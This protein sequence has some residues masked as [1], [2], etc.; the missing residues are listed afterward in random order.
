MNRLGARLQSLLDQHLIVI[1]LALGFGAY[2][3]PS[4]P[5]L[6]FVLDSK[7]NLPWVFVLA[8][9][10]IGSVL[11]ADEVRRTISSWRGV[12]FGTLAQY[13]IMPL[14]AFSLAWFI[15]MSED[16]RLGLIIC[17][18]VPG[19]MASNV[20]TLMARGNVSYSVGVTTC[21]TFLSPVVVPIMFFLFL[22]ASAQ[23]NLV[24]TGVKL[25]WQV[26]LPVMIGFGL[27]RLSRTYAEFMAGWGPVLANLAV[28]WIVTFVVAENRMYLIDA[29]PQLFLALL[30]LNLLGYVG[31]YWAAR[32]VGMDSFTTR[33]L[34]LEVGMQNAGLGTV[35]AM[36]IF[37]GRPEICIPT[38]LYT[39]GCVLTGTALA[40]FWSQS[41]I[42]W[43]K[44]M[45]A[46]T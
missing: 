30:L 12:V 10:S 28:L 24:G 6:D 17:G 40:W 38:A 31:G 8:M 27:A 46:E 36:Q 21:S 20:V 33:A 45:L 25:L 19:A 41:D 2:C 23:T 4:G 26:V 22:G 34:S 16:L 7:P 14:L 1:L 18:C 15:P 9:L 44:E 37:P 35:L 29:P 3:M 11:P 42:R 32:G 39:F 13:T 43:K 5:A